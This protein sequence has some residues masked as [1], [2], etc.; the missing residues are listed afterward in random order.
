MICSLKLI[1]LWFLSTSTLATKVMALAWRQSILVT[2][3]KKSKEDKEVPIQTSYSCFKQAAIDSTWLQSTFLELEFLRKRLKLRGISYL[4][5]SVCMSE[6]SWK[7]CIYEKK[8]ISKL[9][10]SDI[11][12]ERRINTNFHHGG[13]LERRVIQILRHQRVSVNLLMQFSQMWKV[14]ETMTRINFIC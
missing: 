1:R 12:P 13:C 14:M 8:V 5:N 3:S 9:R 7:P 11:W 4:L 10:A 2:A 6:E